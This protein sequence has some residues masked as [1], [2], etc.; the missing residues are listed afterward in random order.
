[1]LCGSVQALFDGH[2]EEAK[3]KCSECGQEFRLWGKKSP[4]WCSLCDQCWQKKPPASVEDI[5]KGVIPNE[6]LTA[7]GAAYWDTVGAKAVTI[8][9]KG[10]LAAAL[11][12]SFGVPNSHHAG[13]IA[14]TGSELIVVDMGTVYGE[15]L[16][17]DELEELR[18][19]SEQPKTNRASLST[20]NISTEGTASAG[21]LTI[22]GA[23]SIKAVFP[24]AVEPGNAKKPLSIRES[25]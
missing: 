25:K 7:C 19:H 20:V 17:I 5:A 4:T 9:R 8:V 11:G 3:M 2:E 14:A 16:T 22:T 12:G 6:N 1:M 10:F 15:D 18:A 13:V 21:L 23:I 24:E